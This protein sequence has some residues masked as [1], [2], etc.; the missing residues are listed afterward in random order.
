MLRKRELVLS[1]IMNMV[2]V[3]LTILVFFGTS[4]IFSDLNIPTSYMA[5]FVVQIAVMWS[6]LFKKTNMGVVHRSQRMSYYLQG[7]IFVVIFGVG[8]LFIESL[9]FPILD[10]K[11]KLEFF[12]S[13]GLANLAVLVLFKIL[14]YYGMTRFR[15]MGLNSRNFVIVTNNESRIFIDTFIKEKDWG[16]RLHSI[17]TYDKKLLKNYPEAHVITGTTS[18]ISYLQNNLVDDV[19]YCLAVNDFHYD[20]DEVLNFA[21]VIGVNMHIQQ[22]VILRRRRFFEWKPNDY[23]FSFT[24]HQTISHNYSALKIK[25]AFETILSAVIVLCSLPFMFLL[26]LLIKLEDGGP[27]FFKQERIG[28]NGRRFVCFKFR[29]MVRN[30]EEMIEEI[31]HL[32]ESDG[33]TFK[34]KNDPRMT[35][36]GRLLR[37]TSFDEFPQFYNVIKGEMAIVG[38]RPPLLK[39]VQ[40]YT[41]EQL[42]RLSVKPGITCKWQVEG[43]NLVSFEEW[44]RMDLEYIDNWSLWNDFKIIIATIGVV[45]KANGR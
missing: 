26:A 39:E 6:Y 27:V 32:N 35:K 21:K 34:I 13:F 23:E 36:V 5:V 17:V 9:L 3:L 7:Y 29:S 8:I 33:P 42:R 30:A 1:R 28:M 40:Q 11:S 37:M 16:Y 25:Y 24:S 38:P 19:F 15:R 31:Q 22:S 20:V 10:V 12:L 45:L 4:R 41:N 2:Q 43:R 18:L 44:M 14:F